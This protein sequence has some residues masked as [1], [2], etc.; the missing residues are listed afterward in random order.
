MTQPDVEQRR[1]RLDAS[2]GS[3]QPMTLVERF[4]R[5]VE[6]F[7]QRPYVLTDTAALTY[8]EV[9]ERSRAIARGL[10][11]L[12]VAPGDRV[13]MVIDNRPAFVA[14][15][16]AIARLGATA[17][18]INFSYQAADLATV[19]A[20]C[21]AEVL[22][23]ID[24]AIGVDH[25]AVLDELAPGWETGVSSAQVP[26]LRGVVLVD[27]ARRPAALDLTG[28]VELGRRIDEAA[29]LTL[30]SA[31]GPDDACDVVFTSGTSG[32]PL[33][34]VL[35]HDMVLRSAYGSAYHRAMTDGWR[36]CFSLPMYHVF[37]YVE[38]LLAALYVGGAVVPHA[39]FNPR[40]IL[41]SVQ[42][43][44]VQEVLFVPTMSVAVVEEATRRRYDTSSL[45]S[46]F[47]AAAAAPVRLWEQIDQVLG[48]RQVFTGYGQ[49]EVSAATTLT[50][51]GDPLE[52]VAET[53]GRMK[54]GGCAAPADLDGAL[55]AYRTVDPFSG[56]ALTAGAEGELSVR[57]PIVTRGY[58]RDPERS[59]ALIDA[60]GWL[61]TGDLGRVR[62][63]GYLELTGRSGEL[64]KVGG[65]L[66]A[67]KQVEQVLTGHPDVEQAYVAGVPDNR[68]GEV[69]W[70]WVVRT[71]GSTL[72]EAELVRHCR[73]QLAGFKVP[74]RVVFADADALPKTTTGK[75]QKFVL[76]REATA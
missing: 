47:S 15:K 54:L 41:T 34:A 40:S 28:L 23:G 65:E 17:V 4:D 27:N 6:R 62:P 13:A 31:A 56:A 70:A 10:F 37:G 52:A 68:L 9:Q 50:L 53:V 20:A 45:E 29:V 36:I 64:F 51:P 11:A 75:I 67:P 49:T 71:P 18:P 58:F 35:T 63:D 19:L 5:A 76:I 66:V 14:V 59:A 33:G 16:L 43:H 25:L 74:R 39:V 12:G 32:H 1:A 73:D 61:R 55:A 72:T 8:A 22:I 2:L 44:R 46:V 24:A 57:G 3:W 38:G 26:R 21:E 48:P 69:G 60:D 30:E 7:G 42:A